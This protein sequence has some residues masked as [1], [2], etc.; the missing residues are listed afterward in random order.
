MAKDV[1]HDPVKNALIK[2]GWA[3][4]AE[5]FHVAYEELDIFADLV[6]ERQPVVAEKD[7]QKI[8]V[9]IKSFAGRSFIREFQQAIG[10]YELYLEMIEL[11]GLDYELYLAVSNYVYETFFQRKGTSIIVQRKQI[12]FVVVDIKQEEIITWIH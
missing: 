12:K 11:A 1:I 2:N 5:H 4:I 9:E 10:Q 3:I 6:A 7:G 8:I